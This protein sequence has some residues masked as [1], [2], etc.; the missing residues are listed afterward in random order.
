MPIPE[1]L[2]PFRLVRLLGQGGMGAVY[3]AVQSGTPDLVALKVLL[4]PADED[5]V[6]RERFEAEIDTLKR[7]RHPN[8]VRLIGFGEAEGFRYFAMEYVDG[9]SLET[10]LRR[11]HRF[12]WEE[13]VHIGVNTAR[14]LRHAHDRGII[15]RDIKPANI[16]LSVKGEIKVSDY[17]IA[18]LFGGQRMTAL[19]TVIGTLEY[20]SPEQASSG[21]ITPK[22][23]LFSLGA[24]L[25]AVLT[26]TPPFPLE[27]K[28]LPEL[29][30]KFREGPVESARLRRPDLPRD[31][32][33][34]LS[35][36][37]EISADKRPP[38]ALIVQRRLEAI[39]EKHAAPGGLARFFEPEE[40]DGGEEYDPA[41]AETVLAEAA[42]TPSRVDLAAADTAAD[43]P[44]G[45][46]TITTGVLSEKARSGSLS[47]EWTE[48]EPVSTSD[49][50]R[51]D[52]SAPLPEFTAVPEEEFDPYSVP[53]RPPYLSL[54][55]LVF[56]L[57]LLLAGT[58][59]VLALRHPSADRLYGRIESCLEGVSPENESDYVNALRQTRGDMSKFLTLYPN[60][61]RADRVRRLSG[62]L[63]Y[64][65]LESRLSR[66]AER[67]IF[68]R[69]PT[70]SLIEEAY[71]EA[72]RAAERDPDEGVRKFRAFLDIFERDESQTSPNS[73]PAQCVRLA[74][75]RLERLEKGIGHQEDAER[76]LVAE[77]LEYARALEP[78]DPARAERIRSGLREFYGNR[79]W[80]GEL[81][82]E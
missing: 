12:T 35:D 49:V 71:I 46:R 48:S 79:P 15:H 60:D 38:N 80:A 18:H 41:R 44:D 45:D 32:D 77:Q 1:V 55:T 74:R 6:R 75:R 25:Y 33:A 37:L 31:L 62:D 13:A 53:D 7:L 76:D 9:A 39:L 36:L 56:S 43:A 19:D 63:E 29:L 69:D 57:F 42:P 8:I 40:D 52:R 68:R 51:A 70:G 27:K 64:A 23:D 11:K 5:S 10:R 2:G 22:T 21:P 14:A 73:V 58:A 82:G 3:E 72:L 26:K 24:V 81:F 30:N 78:T 59:L 17:G 54:R 16:L 4:S 28:S 34:L 65:A 50:T 20:M 47:L 66:L 61:P 67:S